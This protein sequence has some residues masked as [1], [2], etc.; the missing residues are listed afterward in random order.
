ME[1]AIWLRL[2]IERGMFL[3]EVMKDR[4]AVRRGNRRERDREMISFKIEIPRETKTK[5]SKLKSNMTET[6][7]WLAVPSTPGFAQIFAT[8]N[9]TLPLIPFPVSILA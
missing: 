5:S 3:F 9:T 1:R 7:I 8:S 4:S 6:Q 2:W